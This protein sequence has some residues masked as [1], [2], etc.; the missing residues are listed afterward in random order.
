MMNTMLILIGITTY[1][2]ITAIST[3]DKYMGTLE[4]N[5]K[6]ETKEESK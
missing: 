1:L 4:E 6:T 5:K 2:I 3:G